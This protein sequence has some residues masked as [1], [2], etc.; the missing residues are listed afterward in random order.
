MIYHLVLSKHVVW[1]VIKTPHLVGSFIV[2][3]SIVI[4]IIKT[5]H[6]VGS[7]IVIVSILLLLLIIIIIRG[8]ARL[9]FAQFLASWNKIFTEWFLVVWHC[10]HMLWYDLDAQWHRYRRFG[11]NSYVTLRRP[12]GYHAKI[13]FCTEVSP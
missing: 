8:F 11:E 3:V 5:P 6:V 9:S 13:E 12:N 2:I 10:A 7:F 1:S 4:I